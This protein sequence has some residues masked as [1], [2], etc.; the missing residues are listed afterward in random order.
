M[1]GIS[2]P[3][4]TPRIVPT[5]FSDKREGKARGTALD[6][7][8]DRLGTRGCC[9]TFHR[10]ARREDW[11]TMA[12]QGFTLPLD[13]LDGLIAKLLRGWDIVTMDEALRRRPGDR[14]FVNLSIDD[15]YRDTWELAVPL[16]RAHGVPVTIYVT[17]GIPDGGYEMWRVGLETILTERDEVVSREGGMQMKLPDLRAKRAAFR[18]LCRE[19]EAAAEPAAQ[20]RAFCADNRFDPAELHAR[21][22]ITWGMLRSLSNDPCVEI[23]AH[24][25]TH[26]RLSGLSPD[27]ALVEMVD[28]RARLEAE[29]HS[30]VRHFAFP[31]GRHGDCGPREFELARQAGFASAATTRKGLIHPGAH[32]NTYGLPRNTLKAARGNAARLASHLTGVSGALARMLGR[33]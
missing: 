22:A 14:R 2:L 29:L 25:V 18:R 15:G 11:A 8:L 9:L 13:W 19:W 28:S 17:T 4:R 32:A 3:A 6:A 24:T 23:G 31:F 20:Y 30:P 16:F 27:A 10:V 21:H 26:R 12:D 5:A 33:N 1:R 7:V